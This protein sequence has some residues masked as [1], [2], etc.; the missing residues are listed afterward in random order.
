M[1]SG[2]FGEVRAC[3][4]KKTKMKRA[5]KIFKKKALQGDSEVKSMIATEFTVLKK[6]V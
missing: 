5:V 2:S 3:T 4:H 1:V 6:L